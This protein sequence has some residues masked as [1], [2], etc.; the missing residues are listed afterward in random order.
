METTSGV[1]HTAWSAHM[2]KDNIMSGRYTE[3]GNKN[4]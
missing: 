2:K 4:S 3:K 1:L